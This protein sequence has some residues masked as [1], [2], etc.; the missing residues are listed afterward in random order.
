MVDDAQL[1][2]YAASY[3]ENGFVLVKGLLDQAEAAAYREECHALAKRLNN[4]D[5]T[6]GS[7][8]GLAMGNQTELKHCH[9]V[10]FYS[11]AFA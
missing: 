1:A 6:W 8:R 11:G 9:D 7:A 2:S 3:A 5:P 4:P 10:Q